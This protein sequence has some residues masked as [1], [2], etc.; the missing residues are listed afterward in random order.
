M[1]MPEEYV[2]AI[3]DRDIFSSVFDIERKMWEEQNRMW[4]DFMPL[5][6]EIDKKFKHFEDVMRK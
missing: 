3:F 4:E 5:E 2:P 6:K 1:E